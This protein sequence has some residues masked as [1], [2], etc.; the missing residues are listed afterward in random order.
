M[1]SSSPPLPS[2]TKEYV[3]NGILILNNNFESNFEERRIALE[4]VENE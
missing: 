3:S 2:S 1:S 4:T